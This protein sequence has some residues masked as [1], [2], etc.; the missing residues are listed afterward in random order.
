LSEEH[1]SVLYTVLNPYSSLTSR[2][3]L[4]Y[5]SRYASTIAGLSGEIHR[6]D[7]ARTVHE[8]LS[9]LLG[10]HKRTFFDNKPPIEEA[11][12]EGE[13]IEVQPPMLTSLDI[14][15]YAYLKEELVNQRE[16]PVVVHLVKT[17]GNLVKFVEYM[18]SYL[19]RVPQ[20]IQLEQGALQWNHS[21]DS[22][23][24]IVNSFL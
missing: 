22:A 14:V 24:K 1:S 20:V 13:R 15:A 7:A 4:H 2:L 12:E 21:I 16:S 17:Y 10:E 23:R 3:S 6:F 18:D 5:F 9:E 19:T 11:K 8:R